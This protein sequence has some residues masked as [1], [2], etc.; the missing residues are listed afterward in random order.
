MQKKLSKG[1]RE[2]IKSIIILCSIAAVIVIVAAVLVVPRVIMHNS[3][4]E[5]V[6]TCEAGSVVTD[7]SAQ[8]EDVFTISNGYFS[9]DIPKEYEQD[10]TAANPMLDL[11][12]SGEKSMA[13]FKEPSVLQMSLTNPLDKESIGAD[14]EPEELEKM[15][16]KLGYGT[17]DCY[18]NIM[19][20]AILL[21]KEDYSFW[22]KDV[23][24]AFAVV[25]NLKERASVGRKLWN[26]ERG[27]VCA[28][29]SQ[30]EGTQNFVVEVV[31]A[32]NLKQVFSMYLN[33]VD[34][35][36]VWKLLNSVEFQ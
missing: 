24:V 12:L 3:I 1:R 9:V 35:A 14:V 29:I 8:A 33:N 32:Q 23:Q 7:F 17:P 10:A 15:V 22:D 6:Q 20:A 31:N 13:I 11:Y 28:I 19:K 4:K 26:Y 36:D 21:D 5:L 16:A 34:E 27:D 2:Q 18:Y 30:Y 25:A